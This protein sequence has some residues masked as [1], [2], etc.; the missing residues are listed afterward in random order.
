MMTVPRWLPEYLG[1]TAFVFIARALLCNGEAPQDN[2]LFQT[3]VNFAAFQGCAGLHPL[4]GFALFVV[5]T[6][7]WLFIGVTLVLPLAT[8]LLANP[9]A[10]TIAGIAVVALIGVFIAW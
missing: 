5:F 4:M 2:N 10:G 8:G 7:P 1:V 3:I 9:I 6:L